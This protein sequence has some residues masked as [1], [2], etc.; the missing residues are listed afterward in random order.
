MSTRAG[1]FTQKIASEKG[2]SLR[3]LR[4]VFHGVSHQE[5]AHLYKNPDEVIR[6]AV[7]SVAKPPSPPEVTE[8]SK[9]GSFRKGFR[10]ALARAV[11]R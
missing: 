6:R 10:E 9:P 11:R 2:L 3:A 1:K 7:F 8:P 4:R 5:R